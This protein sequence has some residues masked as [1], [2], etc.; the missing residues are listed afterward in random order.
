MEDN[1]NISEPL[2]AGSRGGKDIG[3]KNRK[4]SSTRDLFPSDNR[5]PTETSVL[6]ADQREVIFVGDLLTTSAG[7]GTTT[8]HQKTSFVESDGKQL[9]LDTS[10][11]SGVENNN[12]N[13]GSRIN[14][15]QRAGFSKDVPFQIDEAVKQ[16]DDT[17]FSGNNT[18]LQ[19]QQ[20]QQDSRCVDQNDQHIVQDLQ[21]KSGKKSHSMDANVVPS[22]SY[23]KTVVIDAP[24]LPPIIVTPILMRGNT[25]DGSVI[26]SLGKG[27]T[28]MGSDQVSLQ[29]SQ[30]R[31]KSPPRLIFHDENN[32]PQIDAAITP[33]DN[34]SIFPF[35]PNSK[36]FSNAPNEVQPGETSAPSKTDLMKSVAAS[37]KTQPSTSV[38]IA[39]LGHKR[40]PPPPLLLTSSTHGARQRRSRLNAPLQ[41]HFSEDFLDLTTTAEDLYVDDHLAK[42]YIVSPSLLFGGLRPPANH[43]QGR[44]RDN[45]LKNRHFSYSTG[46]A[47]SLVGGL[48]G[49]STGTTSHQLMANFGDDIS[50]YGTPKEDLSPYKEPDPSKSLSSS[51]LKEQIISFFQPSDNK[52]A[53]KLFGN[54]KALMKE[55]LRQKEAGSWIIHPCSN[56]R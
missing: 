39:S 5:E 44:T 35:A 27:S 32:I 37:R 28:G 45:S 30:G 50:L 54:K 41:H 53:M 29:G 17:T 46:L 56:F 34:E 9:M 55:K 12:N 4:Q 24:I 19:Q 18:S 22:K 21:L 1:Y 25:V 51:Y 14:S 52:L 2:L 20:Q 15:N 33:L 23:P 16:S 38:G 8:R 6:L 40:Q 3:A 42:D 10:V 11:I 7:L 31:R 49:S 48:A 47:G 43:G 13:N 36:S 26:G